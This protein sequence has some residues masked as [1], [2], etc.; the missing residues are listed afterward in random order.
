MEQEFLISLFM[1]IGIDLILGGDNAIVI[2]LACRNL[3]EQ[4][5]QKAIL[6]GTFLAITVRIVLTSFAVILLKIPFLQLIG[7]LFLLF[8]A[9]HLIVGKDEKN[10]NIQSHQSLW[11]AVKTIV[12]ADILMGLDNVVAIAGAANGKTTL[13]IIG[14]LISVPIIIWG[15]RFILKLLEHF[16]GLVYV[17]GGMLAFTA[18]KMINQEHNLQPF[19]LY[20]PHLALSI[21]YVMTVFIIAGGLVYNHFIQNRP[22]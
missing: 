2:A 8:I 6:L 17:G 4:Q 13:V 5:R 14:L 15:S 21:P 3:A 10:D 20:H 19:L 12:I 18:G 22:N 16:P 9:Y 7:G 11:K 1:I